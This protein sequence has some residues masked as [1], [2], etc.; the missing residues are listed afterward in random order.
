MSDSLSWLIDKALTTG[1]ISYT[2]EEKLQQ[3]LH[4]LELYREVLYNVENDPHYNYVFNG[5]AIQEAWNGALIT[6]LTFNEGPSHPAVRSLV[7]GVEYVL[8]RFSNSMELSNEV[9]D[10][11]KFAEHAGMSCVGSDEYHTH[12]LEFPEYYLKKCKERGLT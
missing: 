7:L 8:N 10:R 9:W 6:N 2:Q 4:D 3:E 1:L 12:H 5:Y 11:C